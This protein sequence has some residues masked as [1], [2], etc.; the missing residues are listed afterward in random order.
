[1]KKLIFLSDIDMDGSPKVR[2]EVRSDTVEEYQ[3]QY[4]LKGNRMPE[5]HLF[6][7]GKMFIIGDGWHRVTAMKNLKTKA[8]LFE[9]HE[10]GYSECLKFALTANLSHGLRRTNA[11]KRAGAMS[12]IKEFPSLSNKELSNI[13]AVDDHT[14]ATVRTEMEASLEVKAVSKRQ[15][16][17]GKTYTAKPRTASEIPRVKP[18]NAK[19]SSKKTPK[20]AAVV[21]DDTGI[22]IPPK[23]MVY[24]DRREEVTQLLSAITRIKGIIKQAIEEKDALFHEVNGNDMVARCEYLYG[25]L[26][27]AMPYAVCPTCQ[28]K[29]PEKCS[30]C[31][32]KAMVSK[33]RFGLVPQELITIRGKAA[34]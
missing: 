16:A 34:K 9:I 18:Q 2:A 24:W 1:M 32:G 21:K 14:I 23:A 6:K 25:G 28:G 13:C 30:M 29:L 31:G 19:D 3:S 11:D 22:A 8:A 17:D 10:G 27:V 20:D 7:S 26:K 4:R 12:A 33:H 15:G 5:P